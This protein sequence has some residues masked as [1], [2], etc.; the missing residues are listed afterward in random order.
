MM[1]IV[2]PLTSAK[3]FSGLWLLAT[4][5]ASVT[6]ERSS[7]NRSTANLRAVSGTY[8]LLASPDYAQKFTF[9]LGGDSRGNFRFQ[10]YPYAKPYACRPVV[11]TSDCPGRSLGGKRGRWAVPLTGMIGSG[12][13]PGARRAGPGRALK[14]FRQWAEGA[15]WERR[16]RGSARPRV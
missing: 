11:S 8:Q 9:R 10:L 7:I 12:E 1:S 14:N 16:C 13:G 3:G 2:L 6:D 5:C 15:C 4:F